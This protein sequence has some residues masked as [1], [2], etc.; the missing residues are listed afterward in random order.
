MGVDAA[1][2]AKVSQ[3]HDVPFNEDV[4]W[5]N[6]SVEDPISGSLGWEKAVE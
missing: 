3:L 4:L 6:I 2:G 1:T 5:F